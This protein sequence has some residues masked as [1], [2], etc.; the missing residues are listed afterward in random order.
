M[1]IGATRTQIEEY[2]RLAKKAS[3]PAHLRADVRQAEKPPT[4]VAI[5]SSP[6]I[7]PKEINLS[8]RLPSPD[9]E[10]TSISQVGGNLTTLFALLGK[11]KGFS[12]LISA[13]AREQ[14]TLTGGTANV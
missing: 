7:T 14:K 1:A 6:K 4:D 3:T 12:E 5:I 11:D 2:G 13:A 10:S 8:P 9:E